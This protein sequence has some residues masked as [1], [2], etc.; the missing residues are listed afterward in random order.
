MNSQ[1]LSDNKK[2]INYDIKN[3][4][5]IAVILESA[6]ADGEKLLQIKNILYKPN[7]KF[8]NI[9][10]NKKIAFGSLRTILISPDANSVKISKIAAL[11]NNSDQFDN[12]I[13]KTI[14]CK[15]INS[16]VLLNDSDDR[17]IDKIIF[18]MNNPTKEFDI[19]TDYKIYNNQNFIIDDLLD[20][21]KNKCDEK[22]DININTREL[23]DLIKKIMNKAIE[24]NLCPNKYTFISQLNSKLTG[25][26]H[27]FEVD[28][29][30]T[31]DV[32]YSEKDSIIKNDNEFKRRSKNNL[33]RK[34]FVDFF[35]QN[36]IL[37]TGNIKRYL[38]PKLLD[39]HDILK[40]FMS[41]GYSSYGLLSR[42][43]LGIDIL[44]DFNQR[45]N[46][47]HPYKIML[48]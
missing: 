5:L 45:T 41:A 44:I 21:V 9:I 38:L 20:F 2:S 48:I 16:V 27:A 43:S 8:N 39:L 15:L 37:I 33:L 22:D 30:K 32:S 4:D 14:S 17:K 13:N 18:I 23:I 36:D 31:A 12:I 10:D 47:I 3:F 28:F 29:L 1:S 25:A 11:I 6:T 19:T 40:E 35:N 34:L 24:N 7:H 46:G 26:M 42:Y